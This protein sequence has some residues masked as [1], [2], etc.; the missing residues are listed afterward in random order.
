[1][2]GDPPPFP[3]GWGYPGY[4]FVSAPMFVPTGCICPPGANKDCERPDCPRK[5]PMKDVSSS[6]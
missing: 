5:N 3:P 1:M 6:G 4:P 2:A